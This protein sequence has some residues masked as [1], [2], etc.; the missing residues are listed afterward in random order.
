MERI[1]DEMTQNNEF[2]ALKTIGTNLL[3]TEQKPIENITVG[4]FSFLAD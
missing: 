2:L 4:Y 3:C 1:D